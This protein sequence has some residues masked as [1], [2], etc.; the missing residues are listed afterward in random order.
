M[1]LKLKGIFS[2]P[3]SPFDDNGVLDPHYL[4]R[5]VEFSI[6]S[7]A[8]ALIGPVIASEVWFLS[9]DERKRFME[10][11]T[12]QAARRIPVI[13][14]VSS[15][16][17]KETI[18]LASHAAASGADAVIA[19]LPTVEMTASWEQTY[20]FYKR[21]ADA[22]GLEIV[23]QNGG[24]SADDRIPIGN[25]MRLLEEIPQINYIKDEGLPS[26]HRVTE[27]VKAGGDRLHGVFGGMGGRYMID[28]MRR[29]ACGFAPISTFTDVLVKIWNSFH[30]GNE[31]AAVEM[32]EKLATMLNIELQV[33]KSFAK[34]LLRRR[35]LVGTRRRRMGEV[36]VDEHDLVEL[37][38]RFRRLE[39]YFQPFTPEQLD[40]A[41]ARRGR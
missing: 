19:M 10:T 27:L 38:L 14:G 26:N 21:L 40:A 25:L 8:A 39:P 30:A 5:Q 3:A 6:A 28:E 20:D 33:G 13:A 9:N 34:E 36:D 29:G 22:T 7:G 11:I 41:V 18:D 4:R 35:G 15:N 31:A 37:D 24:R 2:I 12:D 23:I 17:I 32:H 1:S 16:S